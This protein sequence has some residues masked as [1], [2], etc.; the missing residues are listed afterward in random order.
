M[1]KYILLQ[2]LCIVGYLFIGGLFFAYIKISYELFLDGI[3]AGV[4]MAVAVVIA[5][6]LALCAIGVGNYM[7]YWG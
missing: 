1:F 5:L 4:S 7:L 3:W 2:L 6:A